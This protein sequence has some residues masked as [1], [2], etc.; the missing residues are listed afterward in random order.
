[1]D[2]FIGYLFQCP[3]ETEFIDSFS[4]PHV[5]MDIEDFFSKRY[6]S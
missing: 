3:N 2:I 6:I 5:K 1:M 4:Q